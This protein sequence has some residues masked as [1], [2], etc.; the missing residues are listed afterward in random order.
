MKEIGLLMSNKAEI[1][2]LT[3]L[4][5]IT[6]I[7]ELLV[8]KVLQES[9]E[10]KATVLSELSGYLSTSSTAEAVEAVDES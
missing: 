8:E 6:L 2:K 10:T 4:I 7:I 9:E 5:E 3:P 1:S